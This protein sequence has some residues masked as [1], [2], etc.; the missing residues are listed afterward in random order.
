MGSRL[1]AE[2]RHEAEL[3]LVP[4]TDVRDRR[5]LTRID[6]SNSTTRSIPPA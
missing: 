2:R 4:V 3:R 1:S 5:D 6:A